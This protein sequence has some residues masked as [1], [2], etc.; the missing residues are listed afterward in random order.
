MTQH[1]LGVPTNSTK[2]CSTK[3]GTVV[4][5]TFSDGITVDWRCGSSQLMLAAPTR[6]LPQLPVPVASSASGTLTVTALCVVTD[7]LMPNV[8]LM[9]PGLVYFQNSARWNASVY[10]PVP[11]AVPPQVQD[12]LLTI[13]EFCVR[14]SALAPESQQSILV[15]SQVS[16]LV[17][18]IT[19]G[20][21]TTLTVDAGLV[22]LIDGFLPA[23]T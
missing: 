22:T 5:L 7:R 14:V 23:I 20:T 13:G 2:L 15:G 6:P 17:N 18:F 21:S 9:A 3:I 19:S 8:G 1:W 11:I 10:C 16:P 4:G 12:W